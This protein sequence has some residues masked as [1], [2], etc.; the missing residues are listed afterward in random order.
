MQI[1]VNFNILQLDGLQIASL[2]LF[3]HQLTSKIMFPKFKQNP[4][5]S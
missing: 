1:K 2:N 3:L 4:E 5:S